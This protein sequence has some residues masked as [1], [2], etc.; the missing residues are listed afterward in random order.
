MNGTCQRGLTVTFNLNNEQNMFER[1]K[2][3]LLK[4][5]R[6][7]SERVKGLKETELVIIHRF[8]KFNLFK[9]TYQLS[10]RW[11]FS[12]SVRKI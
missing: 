5:E 6:N 8:F 11:H 3:S 7:M 9:Y 2:Q 12:Y 10:W 1:V 4:N